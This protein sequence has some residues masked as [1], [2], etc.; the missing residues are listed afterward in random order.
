MHFDFD[1]RV[2]IHGS[3]LQPAGVAPVAPE[4]VERLAEDGLLMA[5]DLKKAPAFPSDPLQGRFDHGVAIASGGVEDIAG[6]AIA[7][8]AHQDGLVRLDVAHHQCQVTTTV[9]WP[10]SIL[11][12]FMVNDLLPR[13]GWGGRHAP[14][15]RHI[16]PPGR[17]HR[18]AP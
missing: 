11:V 8:H 4:P 18:S 2:K 16:R 13:R 9:T 14:W 17:R 1:V 12:T 15:C 10:L 7:V 6:Q 5:S 3:R